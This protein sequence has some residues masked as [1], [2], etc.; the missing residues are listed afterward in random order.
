MSTIAE[1]SEV[2]RV[3]EVEPEV[4]PD[5]A[6]W[7]AVRG[8]GLLRLAYLLTGHRVEAEDIVRDALSRALP[9]W[10]R[11]STAENPDAFMRRMVVSSH[12]SWWRKLR[13][14]ETPVDPS[15]P[16]PEPGP[17][18]EPGVE[19][20]RDVVWA[21]CRRLP[22]AQRTAVVLRY[23]EQ[24]EDSEIAE[25]TGVR[26]ATVRSRIS[27]GL[28]LLRDT[29][30]RP[31][32]ADLET[33]LRDALAAE[34]ATIAVPEHLARSAHI[35][36]RRRRRT[37]VWVAAAVLVAVALPAGVV[38]WL[39][40]GAD[41]VSGGPDGDTRVEAYHDVQIRVPASWGYGNLSTWCTRSRGASPR[42]VVERPGGAVLSTVCGEPGQ[43]YGVQF[44]D[45]GEV[46]PGGDLGQYEWAPG[47]S[48]QAYPN[49]AWVGDIVVGDV[50]LR[51][52]A[53][54]EATA[55]GV[56]DSA[57]V[58]DVDGHGC[59]TSRTAGRGALAEA[60]PGSQMSICRYDVEG[61]LV[62]SEQL[63]EADTATALAALGNPPPPPGLDRPC[64][65]TPDRSDT[66]VMGAA[67]QAWQLVFESSC[68]GRN[69]VSDAAGVTIGGL[70]AEILYWAISPGWSGGVAAGVPLP[71]RLRTLPD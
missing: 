35:R 46:D 36:L 58:V 34:A 47:A 69:V 56:L 25:L 14:R 10:A 38:G 37:S 17:G 63:N 16:A 43:S 48:N 49:G 27:R 3:A 5:F 26:E 18:V 12:T 64:P 32:V 53:R 21:A 51:V 6:E 22:E 28:D 44:L 71:D 52:V 20:G 4:P 61:N 60:P 33:R 29:W 62:Q 67:G 65:A 39:A 57:E 23:H 13:R 2:A 31:T 68:A 55:R 15:V 24:L 41:P 1:R 19:P 9:R 50:G 30:G 11:L 42:P 66:I 8:P 70:T 59:R 54:D 7:V 40:R 45:P